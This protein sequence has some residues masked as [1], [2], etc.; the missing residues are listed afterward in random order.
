LSARGVEQAALHERAAEAAF[1]GFGR[2]V[3]VRGVVEVSNF[4]RENCHYFG[5]RRDNRALA[6][7]RASHE[8]LV[9]AAIAHERLTP[10]RQGLA[11][12]YRSA[13]ACPS[14]RPLAAR[15]APLSTCQ[16]RSS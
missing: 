10:S 2:R 16:A 8:H 13:T 12:F 14:S 15:P 3:F 11:S 5:M 9:L 7:A 4:C 6:R 1:Q